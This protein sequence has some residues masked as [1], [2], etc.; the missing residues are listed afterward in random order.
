MAG[1]RQLLV[2]GNVKCLQTQSAGQA[3][4]FGLI[5]CVESPGLV[6][7]GSRWFHQGYTGL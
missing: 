7:P 6:L 4:L 5:R 3:M 2:T 1:E